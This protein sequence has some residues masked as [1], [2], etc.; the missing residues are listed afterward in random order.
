MSLLWILVGVFV[1]G[2]MVLVHEWGHFVVAKLLGVRVEVFSIGFGSRIFGWRRGATDYRL[3][4]LPLG[5][6]VKMAGDN[7]SDERAGAPDEFLSQR[8]WR[9]ALIVVAGPATNAVLAVALLAG[10]YAVRFEKPTYLE[11]PA[12]LEGVV[13]D[14]PA[15]RAGLQAGD[16]IV[17]IAGIRNPTWEQVQ[18][19]TVLSGREPVPVTLARGTERL[20]PLLQPEL[21]GPRQT[22]FIGWYPYDPLLI[23]TVDPEM[24]AARAGMRAGDEIV[25]VDGAPTSEVGPAGLV[26][27]VKKSQGTP[28]RFTLRRH[29]QPLELTVAAEERTRQGQTGYFLGVGLGRRLRSVHLGPVAALRQSVVENLRFTGL[30]FVLLQRLLTG[31]VSVQTLEGPIGITILSGQAARRDWGSLVNLMALISIQLA[32]LNLLPIPVMDGGHLA[33]LAVE[34]LR[35]RDLSLGFKERVTQLGLMLLLLLFAV[36]MYNDIVR[37]F[38]R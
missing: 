12:R 9:R 25:A 26:E 29:G 11:E 35:R 37:Y 15:G 21:Q 24:P 16:V 33:L 8:R 6:Y 5:G 4:L 2:L 30:L 22:A 14:S 34:S 19:E 13:A 27:R 3:S 36:V 10:L 23:T 28:L 7:P 38:F 17:E 1:L 32:V 31:R 20:T 18:L